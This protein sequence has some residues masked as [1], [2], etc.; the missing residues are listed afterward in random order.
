MSADL[1]PE[2]VDKLR[3]AD[4]D[5]LG[6][7]TD[8]DYALIMDSQLKAWSTV[9]LATGEQVKRPLDLRSLLP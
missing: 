4:E 1:T 9:T 5:E 6:A 8:K 7:C 3:I 2:D